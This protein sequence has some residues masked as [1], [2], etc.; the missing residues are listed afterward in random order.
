M[1]KNIDQILRQVHSQI[2]DKVWSHVNNQVWRKIWSQFF[3][4][5]QEQVLTELENTQEQVLTELRKFVR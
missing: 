5:T 4:T 2:C 3:K 1:K